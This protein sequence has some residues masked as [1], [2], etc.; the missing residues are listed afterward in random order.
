MLRSLQLYFVHHK[1]PSHLQESFRGIRQIFRF[2]G[3][4]DRR[5]PPERQMIISACH[6]KFFAL[7]ILILLGDDCIG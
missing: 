6:Q 7:A 1:R 3:A 2:P 4:L 5:R